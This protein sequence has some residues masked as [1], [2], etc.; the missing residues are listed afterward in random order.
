[1]NP[2]AW[3]RWLISWKKRSVVHVRLG[4]SQQSSSIE[5]LK[6]SVNASTLER[7]YTPLTGETLHALHWRDS[8]RR[9]RVLLWETSTFIATF[10]EKM[11]SY[12]DASTRNLYKLTQKKGSNINNIQMAITRFF[13]FLFEYYELVL[14]LAS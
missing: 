1:M 7:L 8:T 6:Y 12:F 4:I 14:L 2:R 11:L 3:W 5:T 10:K 9:S 13:R